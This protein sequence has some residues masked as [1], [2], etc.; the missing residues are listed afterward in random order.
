MKNGEKY[1]GRSIESVLQQTYTDFEL[2]IIDDLSDD[3][4]WDI[5]NGYNDLRI[6]VFKSCNGFI[7]NLNYGISVS[8]GGYI[9]RMDA[10]DIMYPKRLECQLRIMETMQVDVCSSWMTIFG[11]D[12]EPFLMEN[13]SGLIVKPLSWFL[14]KNFISHPAT[15]IRK[16][17]L[18]EKE[19]KYNED[20]PCAEDYKL[21]FEAAKVGGIFYIDPEPYLYYRISKDQVTSQHKKEMIQQTY[22]IQTEIFEYLLTHVE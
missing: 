21:W 7:A 11:E 6:K 18:I 2:I 12:F 17:F 15:M 5:I 1:I 14:Y 16:T 20:Y 13:L 22:K 8:K 9:A 3:C 10:D 4:T 19:L